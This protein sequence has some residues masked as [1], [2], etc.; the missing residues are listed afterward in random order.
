MEVSILKQ[1]KVEIFEE[2]G[3]EHSLV[4]I[5]NKKVFT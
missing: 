3:L 5:I 1:G 2:K 4:N